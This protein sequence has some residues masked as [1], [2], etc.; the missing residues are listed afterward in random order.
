MAKSMPAIFF[1]HGNPM[2]ALIHNVWTDGR[3]WLFVSH[4][5]PSPFFSMHV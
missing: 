5:C 1:G 4:D 3:D 2:N